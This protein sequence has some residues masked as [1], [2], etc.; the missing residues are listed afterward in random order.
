MQKTKQKIREYHQIGITLAKIKKKKS[1]L[2]KT[3][4]KLQEYV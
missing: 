3:K 2:Q 1:I 4:E